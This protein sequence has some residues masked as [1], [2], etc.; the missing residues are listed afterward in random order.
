MTTHILDSPRAIEDKYRN[1]IVLTTDGRQYTGL[2]QNETATSVTLVGQNGETQTVLKRDIEEDGF[3]RSKVSM[4]PQGL[5]T[6]LDPQALADVVS[7]IVQFRQPAKPFPG[8]EPR[9]IEP[10]GDNGDLRLPAS[11][12]SIFGPS[13]VF[14][15]NY[16]NLGF[17]SNIDDRAQWH[18]EVPAAGRYDVYLDWAVPDGTANN[19]YVLQIGDSQ[20]TGQ[21][22]STGSWDQY[23]QA[24]I[25]NL[26]L[27]AGKQIAVFRAAAAPSNCLLDLREICIVPAGQQ[28]PAGF[29]G[30]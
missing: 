22:A 23:Q 5:E 15:S 30:E 10:S 25:G 11:A 9:L 29:T 2:L 27:K 7:L 24:R 26:T 14:E 19:P 4:M 28:P 18:I 16:G 1:Y 20:L 17:W 3:R 8:N 12:A 13:L 21:V 6:S